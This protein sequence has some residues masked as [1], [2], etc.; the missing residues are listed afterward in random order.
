LA[1]LNLVD[2]PFQNDPFFNSGGGMF[3]GIDEMMKEMRK[4]MG[5][6]SSDMLGG[7]GRF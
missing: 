1:N 6:I 2:D 7:G 5:M 4:P 3:G